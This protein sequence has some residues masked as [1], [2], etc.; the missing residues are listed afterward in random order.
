MNDKIKIMHGIYDPSL[1]FYPFIRNTNPRIIITMSNKMAIY[2]WDK[3]T[4][5]VK[6]LEFTF[7]LD[8]INNIETIALVHPKDQFNRKLG[9]KIVIGR[10][11]RMRGEIR[12][13]YDPIPEYIYKL[14]K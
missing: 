7:G 11:K 6:H 13:P 5:K 8:P 12:K 9:C 4:K 14:E 10:I 1:H 2:L 3:I